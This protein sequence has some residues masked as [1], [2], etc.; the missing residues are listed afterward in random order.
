MSCISQNFRWFHVSNL[1]VRNFRISAH[2]SRVSVPL[3]TAARRPTGISSP[4]RCRSAMQRADGLRNGALKHERTAISHGVIHV[5]IVAGRC[6]R[7]RVPLS[8]GCAA[9]DSLRRCGLGRLRPSLN[10]IVYGA[11]PRGETLHTR[12]APPRRS[13]ADGAVSRPPTAAR[14][15]KGPIQR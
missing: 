12:R 5:L 11:L 14:Q 6:F 8:V 2:V 3:R 10:K 1:S 13:G 4:P 15:K 7:V 9:G